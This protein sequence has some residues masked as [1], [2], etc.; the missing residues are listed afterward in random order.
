MCG[1]SVGP[2]G[3]LNSCYLSCII[4]ILCHCEERWISSCYFPR[5]N[6]GTSPRMWLRFAKVVR[7]QNQILDRFL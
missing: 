5:E 6:C 1:L 4:V 7:Y 2:I 3:S